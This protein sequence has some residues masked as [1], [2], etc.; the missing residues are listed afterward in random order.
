MKTISKFIFH[1]L[2]GWKTVGAFPT[3]IK[4]YIIIGAPHTHWQDFMLGLAM[5]LTQKLPVN[6]IGKASLFKPPFGFIFRKLGGI[7]IDRS[8]STN[9]VEAIIN[10]FNKRE[11]FI[12]ALSPEGT[13]KRVDTWKTGFYHI[14]K[15]AN[16]PIVMMTFDFENK[17]V[18]IS[19]PYYLTDDKEKD[20]NFIYD[21]Y[22]G[23]KGK[24]P[25]Y[26]NL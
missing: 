8:K 17:Q 23:V 19:K 6:F 26:F 5:K 15:G 1:K 20:M 13:R 9:K 25:E 3:D 2:F 16:V 4:K 11:Q 14:A 18:K 10:I 24:I 22:R 7:P 21:F 12:F